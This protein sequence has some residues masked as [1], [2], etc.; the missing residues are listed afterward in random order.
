MSSLRNVLV[1]A[2]VIG[3]S[4]SSSEAEARFGKRSSS[5]EEKKSKVHDA[6]AVG[7]ESSSSDSDD[8]DA[9]G[10]TSYS[11]P[12][13]RSEPGNAVGAF[14]TLLEILADTPS[15]QTYETY[16]VTSTR[17]PATVSELPETASTST[18]AATPSEKLGSNVR[19]GVDAASVGGGTGISLFLA[20][21]GERMGMDVRG[22]ELTLPTDDGTAGSDSI[23]LANLHLTYAVVARE[24]LRVRIEGG[25]SGAQAPDLSVAAPSFAVSLEGCLLPMVDVEL[26]AQATPF[27]YQQ[28]DA[29]AALALRLQALVVR[30]GW[31][32]LYLNDNGMVEGEAHSDAFGG[33]FLG[34]GFTF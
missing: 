22:T 14:F 25:L 18:V 15:P 4:F 7:E 8:D 29:Q 16:E 31:R 6:T 26:R 21:E 32:A 34:A 13:R 27:P 17:V 11:P 9:G 20:F 1:A 2:A 28:L 19:L 24:N 30:G 5:T 23:K 33:P 12:P 10:S 3:L